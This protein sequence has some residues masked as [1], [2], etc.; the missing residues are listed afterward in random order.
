MTHVAHKCAACGRESRPGALFCD[1]CGAPLKA[2]GPVRDPTTVPPAAARV[3]GRYSVK[4]F[5][6]EGGRKRVYLAHDDMLDRDV[7][8]A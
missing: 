6:G 7:A 3:A 1:G 8:F 4:R 5:L 2:S